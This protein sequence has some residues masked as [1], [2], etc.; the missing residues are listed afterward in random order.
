[1]CGQLFEG[2]FYCDGHCPDCCSD[3]DSAYDCEDAYGE[4]DEDLPDTGGVRVY[5]YDYKPDPEFYGPG[6]V[7]L[8]MELEV[9]VPRSAYGAAAQCAAGR[10][11]ALGYLKE[12][13][14]IE[15]GFEIVTH[16]MTHAWAAES[17]PWSMLPELAALGAHGGDT[18]GIHVHV[19]REGFDGPAHVYRWLNLLY[20]NAAAV[21]AVARRE[22]PQWASFDS[23]PRI[24]DY[25]KGDRY[26][27]RYSAVNVCNYATFEVRVFASSLYVT[28]VRAALDL[29]AGSVEYTRG[30]TVREIVDGGWTWTNFIKWADEQGDTY[31]ALVSESEARV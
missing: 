23:H 12:D 11:G 31:A 2:S 15:C 26:G 13:G 29:V 9:E 28:E 17:F 10:L 16:P 14:T 19:S 18:V 3:R 8:G 7:H 21:T 24:K 4:D 22:S 5:G 25:A 20:R 27:E 30:L 6:S 1:L